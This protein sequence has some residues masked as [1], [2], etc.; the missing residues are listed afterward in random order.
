MHS[1]SPMPR[2]ILFVCLGNICR[3]P[4]AEGVFRELADRA[5]LLEDLV[6]DSAGTGAWHVG[7]SPDRRMRQAALRHGYRLEGRARRVE[8]SDYARFDLIFAM[9]S[10]NLDSLQRSCPTQHAHKV[11]LLGDLD[12]SQPGADVPDPYYGGTRGFDVVVEMVE[13]CCQRLVASL[14]DGSGP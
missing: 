11:R 1:R 9:D 2:K 10:D 4:T 7:E 13:R 8:A 12:S 14:Q 3:S 5:G 6:I